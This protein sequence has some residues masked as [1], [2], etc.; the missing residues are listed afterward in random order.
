MCA[1]AHV[2]LLATLLKVSNGELT[3][4]MFDQSN[5]GFEIYTTNGTHV[6]FRVLHFVVLFCSNFNYHVVVGFDWSLVCFNSLGLRGSLCINTH[7]CVCQ[8]MRRVDMIASND[9]QFDTAALHPHTYGH[10]HTYICL[11]TC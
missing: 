6:C 8:Y 4:T 9:I 1:V 5:L 10:M 7:M 2:S 11:H 3:G